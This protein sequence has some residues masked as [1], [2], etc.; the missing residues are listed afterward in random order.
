MPSPPGF[1]IADG[2]SDDP[3][4]RNHKAIATSPTIKALYPLPNRMPEPPPAARWIETCT[5]L[6]VALSAG[7]TP[8]HGADDRQRRRH[9]RRRE[10]HLE[11]DPVGK[12]RQ[13]I[14]RAR[15]DRLQTKQADA[16]RQARQQQRFGEQL[17]D[18]ASPAGP[19]RSTDRDFPGAA[20]HAREDQDADVPAG[21]R[22]QDQREA[23]REEN[24][25]L[26]LRA[27]HLGEHVGEWQYLGLELRVCLRELVGQALAQ[28][29]DLVP[30]LLDGDAIGEAA[31]D[32][33]GRSLVSFGVERVVPKREPEVVPIGEEK[34]LRHH[35]DHRVRNGPDANRAPDGIGGPGQTRLPEVVPDHDDV[36]RPDGLVGLAE[37]ASCQWRDA[38]QGEDRRRD[39]CPADRRRPSVLRVHVERRRA[40]R[41]SDYG[42]MD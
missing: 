1:E 35:A 39:L 11:V 37:R 19:E 25:H 24:P 18:N 41:R 26:R 17:E 34:S 9:G 20:R 27:V 38:K 6:L 21:Q 23:L 16:S 15:G 12:A 13:Q 40:G 36:R 28:G 32:R 31:D 14:L 10:R 7:T 2:S 42:V 3:R 4:V 5:L 29:L 8:A 22:E 30:R 33:R